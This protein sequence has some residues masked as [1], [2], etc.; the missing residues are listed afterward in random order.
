MNDLFVK[1][2]MVELKRLS[3]KYLYLF[4]FQKIKDKYVIEFMCFY[5]RFE[6]CLKNGDW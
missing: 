5:D 3:V 1:F 2:I 4:I 6:E